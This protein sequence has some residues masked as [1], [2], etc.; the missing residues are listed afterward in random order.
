MRTRALAYR[1]FRQ[2]LRDKRSLAMMFVAPI[3]ILTLMSLIFNGNA[4]KP[5]VAVVNTPATIQSILVQHGAVIH[6][7]SSLVAQSALEDGDIDA[8]ISFNGG[9]PVIKLEGSDPTTNRAVIMLLQQIVQEMNPDTSSPKLNITY[10]HGSAEMTSFDN[11]GPVLVGFFAFFFVFLL[12]GVAFLRERTGGTL[13][14]LLATPIRRWEIVVGYLLGFGIFAMI[15]SAIIAWFSISVL[16]LIL[17]GSFWLVLIST[18]AL[19]MTALTLGTFISAYADNEFQMVQFI[20]LIIVPQ[21]FFSG[22][23][24]MDTMADWLRWLS[25]IMPL[26]Y[27][28]D[29][30]R[31]VMVRGE[32]WS[33][34]AMDIYILLGLSL[35]FIVANVYALRKHR[36]I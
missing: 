26:S 6:E 33:D 18:L 28:A 31:G 23:F 36:K 14:R 22:L 21:V 3:L 24:N 12:S 34:I 27:G 8:I 13:E 25:Y 5:E 17:E 16:G 15:Q 30:L 19:A 20:P 29:A 4:Y 35:F 9:A 1:I 7:Y 2:F 10:L 11:F 32:G